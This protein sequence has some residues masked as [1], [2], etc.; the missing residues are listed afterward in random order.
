MLFCESHLCDLGKRFAKM[1]VGRWQAGAKEEVR[2]SELWSSFSAQSVKYVM[3]VVQIYLPLFKYDKVSAN[4]ASSVPKPPNF[5][6][7]IEW[8]KCF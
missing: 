3:I 1:A 4:T 8:Q 5:K 2:K 7:V 6:M